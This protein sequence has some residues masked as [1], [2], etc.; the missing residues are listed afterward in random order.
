VCF[1]DCPLIDGKLYNM[2][3]D[4]MLRRCVMEREGPLIL[5]ESHEGIGGGLYARK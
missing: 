2:G 4:K 1:A 5:E 3:P